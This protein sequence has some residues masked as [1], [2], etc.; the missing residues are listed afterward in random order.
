MP[1]PGAKPKADRSQI[2]HRVPAV[3]DWTEVEDVP[4]TGAPALR[5]RQTGGVS[6]MVVGA[7]NS[8]GWPA[9]TLKWW[10]AIS[11]MPHAKLWGDSEWVFAMDTAEIHARTVEGW[12]GYTGSNLTAREKQLGVT[13]DFRRDLRIKY[14]PKKAPEPELPADVKRLDD[15]RAL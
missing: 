15:Y 1:V 8:E 11:K 12:R 5:D 14:V 9:A 13:A 7:A 6:V 10:G 4:F 2:T 3:H